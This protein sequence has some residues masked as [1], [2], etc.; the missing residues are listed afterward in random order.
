MKGRGRY[1]YNGEGA[2]GELD[3]AANQ[4]GVGVEAAAPEGLAKHYDGS[5]LLG[6]DEA[7]TRDHGHFSDAEEIGS[8]ALTPHT[9]RRA[10]VSNGGGEE[11]KVGGHTG[12]G[13]CAGA[14][15]GVKRQREGVAAAFSRRGRVK[16]EQGGGIAHRRRL[17]HEAADHGEDGGVGANAQRDR[18]DS[19]QRGDPM[20]R[21]R[22]EAGAQV[23][24]KNFKPG[25]RGAIAIEL[26]RRLGAAE[27]DESLSAGL[28]HGQAALHAALGVQR[29]M[30]FQLRIEVTRAAAGR[31]GVRKAE[32]K[33]TE[34][35]AKAIHGYA[36][37]AG[38]RKRARISVACSHSAT[39]LRAC[40]APALVSS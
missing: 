31:N 30:G 28:S 29:D 38:A 26:A 39:A 27:V 40:L 22:A 6:G 1:A 19:D 17:E 36:S 34:L 15:I 7:A 25:Q 21:E 37:S 16:R 2:A 14:E 35:S 10:V 4:R 13:F 32:K 24:H 8:D 18:K 5:A 12:E 9:L 20:A 33:G 3:W 23:A 11:V